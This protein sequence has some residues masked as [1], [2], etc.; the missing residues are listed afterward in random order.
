MSNEEKIVTA[1]ARGDAFRVGIEYG[2]A[3]KNA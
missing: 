1:V 3:L 2:E